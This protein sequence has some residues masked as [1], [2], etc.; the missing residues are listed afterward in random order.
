MQSNPAARY[1]SDQNPLPLPP[2]NPFA[3]PPNPFGPAPTT[4]PNPFSSAV[5][6]PFPPTASSSTS[7]PQISSR[8]RQIKPARRIDPTAPPPRYYDSPASHYSNRGNTTSR[9]PTAKVPLSSLGLS[10]PPLSLIADARYQAMY[11]TYPSR[12]RLGTSS[13]MQPNYLAVSTNGGDPATTA[14]G[15]APRRPRH[16]INY[17]EIE[18]LEDSEDETNDNE[19][20]GTRKRPAPP[21]MV[22]KRQGESDTSKAQWGDGKSYLGVPPPEHLVIVQRATTT[23]HGNLS[24]RSLTSRCAMLIWVREAR[25][26]S[27]NCKRARNLYSFRYTSTS[28]SIRSRSGIPSSGMQVVGS[29]PSCSGNKTDLFC[30]RETDYGRFVR[31]SVL[32]RSRH[33]S[34]S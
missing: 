1:V 30:R 24:V 12:M 3:P 6:N 5:S 11:T 32:R 20:M 17:A 22:P 9:P 19:G 13:L 27:W 2:P 31:S 28:T 7:T 34:H 21:G 25:R 18:G 16:V 29:E 4:I 14:S 10:V 15:S 33:S 23:K 26:M 8:G